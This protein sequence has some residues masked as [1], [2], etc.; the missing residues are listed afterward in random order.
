MVATIKIIPFAAPQD[1]VQSCAAIAAE[2]APLIRVAAFAKKSVG[3]VQTRLPGVKPVT[4]DK[5]VATTRAR[6]AA[7]GSALAHDLVCDHD[8]AAIAAAIDALRQRGCEMI[9]VLGASAIVD[10]RD[11]IPAA[12]ERSGG[13][14]RSISACRSTPAT[15]CCSARSARCR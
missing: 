3:L 7:L 10:R 2:A 14:D 6:L 15:C 9:L 4:L 13:E 5:T 1:A 11:V 12:I 8:E